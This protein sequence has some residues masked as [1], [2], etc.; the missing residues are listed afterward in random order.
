MSYKVMVRNWDRDQLN[1]V[2]YHYAIQGTFD[3]YTNIINGGDIDEGWTEEEFAEC[4]VDTFQE[5]DFYDEDQEKIKNLIQ[6]EYTED[7]SAINKLAESHRRPKSWAYLV[8]FE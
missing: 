4:V 1:K 7:L 3:L 8:R 5:F 6:E 2:L